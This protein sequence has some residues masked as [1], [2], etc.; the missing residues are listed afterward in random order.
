MPSGVFTPVVPVTSCHLGI[1][2]QTPVYICYVILHR[3][4][5]H[6]V[7][8][9]PH[10]ANG[11]FALY[12]NWY[13]TDPFLVLGGRQK[14][15]IFFVLTPNKEKEFGNNYH[16]NL[17]GGWKYMHIHLYNI[18]IMINFKMF[19][20]LSSVMKTLPYL[21]YMNRIENKWSINP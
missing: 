6:S 16:K 10:Q 18:Y 1:H 17:L 19:I 2:R 21:R 12:F 7:L 3:R 11:V 14:A 15:D 13:T 20:I 9:G 4:G 5:F 8:L